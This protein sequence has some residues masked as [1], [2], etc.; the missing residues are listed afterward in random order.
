MELPLIHLQADDVSVTAG[1][2]LHDAFLPVLPVE[3]PGWAVAVQLPRG[4]LVTKHVVAHD[5]KHGYRRGQR[6]EE[7]LRVGEK[8]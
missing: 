3:G 5:R 1:D 8:H 2:F 6:E 7:T 4:V